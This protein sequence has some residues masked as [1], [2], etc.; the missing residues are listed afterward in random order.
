MKARLKETGEILNIL[1]ET[2]YW[3]TDGNGKIYAE[4]DYDELEF[5]NENELTDE[6]RRRR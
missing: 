2:H 1:V 4:C 5:I 6:E 3:V